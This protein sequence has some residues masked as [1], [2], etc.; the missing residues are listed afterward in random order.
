M[1]AGIFAAK[2][3][4]PDWMQLLGGGTVRERM[5]VG[6]RVWGDLVPWD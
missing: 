5:E 1:S 3:A 2:R 4:K 6:G